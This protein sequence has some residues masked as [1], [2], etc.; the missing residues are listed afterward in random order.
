MNVLILAAYGRIAR[1]VEERILTEEKFNDICLT[2]VLR[3]AK[4][5]SKLA[6]NPRVKIIEGDTENFS[7]VNQAMQGQD[8][9]YVSNV[10]ITPDSTIT[11]NVIQAMKDNG[12][13]RLI[14]SNAVGIYD[15]VPTR[16]GKANRDACDYIWNE[17]LTS[18]KLV[19]ES[20]LDYTIIRLPWLTDG[21][22][23]YE[24]TT[25]NELFYGDYVSRESCADLILKIV[26]DINYGSRDSLALG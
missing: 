1:I 19:T 14:S 5:L 16:F 9:V 4:R 15:E 3:N 25:R 18:E 24:V 8:L 23:D 22:I 13:K 12:V 11:K 21:G 10:D 17:I 26:E 2:L 7:V 6:N 20:G